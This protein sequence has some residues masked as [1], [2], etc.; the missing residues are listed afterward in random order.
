MKVLVRKGKACEECVP[1]ISQALALMFDTFGV[2]GLLE[3]R[4]LQYAAAPELP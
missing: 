2:I 4:H 1:P 3:H